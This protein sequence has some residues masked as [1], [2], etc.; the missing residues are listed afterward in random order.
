[1]TRA[2]VSHA[3]VTTGGIAST[4][5]RARRCNE[6]GR[7]RASIRSKGMVSKFSAPCLGRNTFTAYFVGDYA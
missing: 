2:G 7:K 5:D 1:M 4:P 6:P 3:Y